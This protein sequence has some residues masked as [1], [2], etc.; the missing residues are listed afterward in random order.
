MYPMDPHSVELIYY[1]SHW[2]TLC[3]PSMI[4]A[5]MDPH[6]VPLIDDG[7]RGSLQY[8][9]LIDDGSHG[10]T[11]FT[12][13]VWCLQSLPPIFPPSM[14]M[15]P[16]WLKSSLLHTWPTPQIGD[17]Y[18]SLF[19]DILTPPFFN[20]QCDRLLLE[21]RKIYYIYTHVDKYLLQGVRI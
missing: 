7:S 11:L 8:S 13:Q 6:Y 12:T 21:D 16:S 15:T 18:C 4:M 2:S 5:P 14:M 19:D 20:L 3:T 10:S 9:P 17:Y 1:W